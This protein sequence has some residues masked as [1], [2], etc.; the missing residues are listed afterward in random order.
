MLL[1]RWGSAAILK[2]V[3]DAPLSRLTEAYLEKVQAATSAV[4]GAAPDA[5]ASLSAAPA[6]DHSALAL[7][8]LSVESMLSDP[9]PSRFPLRFAVN[10]LTCYVHVIASR[11]AWERP[12]P[13][14]SV[15]GW[16]LQVHNAPLF[17]ELPVEFK[18]CGKCATASVWS[19]LRD[20]PPGS[21]SD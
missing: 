7:A 15:C 14:R 8:D 6:C 4:L 16:D 3:A 13:G 20:A 2:Y 21:E 5:P 10:E 1:A 11:Q 18:Q 12:K 17:H 19:H 9:T